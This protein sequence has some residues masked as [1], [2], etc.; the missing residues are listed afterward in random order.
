MCY[1]ITKDIV[2]KIIIIIIIIIII[3]IYYIINSVCWISD[4]PQVLEIDILLSYSRC[5]YNIQLD[6]LVNLAG[7]IYTNQQW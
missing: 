4:K 7:S 1:Y 6:I 2:I 5:R 3:Y